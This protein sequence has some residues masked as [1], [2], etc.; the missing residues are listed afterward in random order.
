MIEAIDLRRLQVLRMVREHGTVTAAAAA[1]HLTPSAVSHQLRQLA[2]EVGVEL[3]ERDGRGVRLTAAGHRV[4]LHADRLHAAWEHVQADL[5]ALQDGRVGT[6]RLGAFASGVVQLLVPAAIELGRTLP[7]VE[8][9]LTE[10]SQ[11]ADGFARLLTEEIDVAL[12]SP[13]P[14]G[15]HLEDARF[16]QQRLVVEPMDLV[17]PGDHPLAG[18]ADATLAEVAHEPWILAGPEGWECHQIAASACAAAGFAPRVVHDAVAPMAVGALVAAHLGVALLPRLAPL[19]VG[20]GAVRVPLTGRST[21]TRTILAATRRGS[22]ARPEV[23]A[24]LAALRAVAA[25]T[26]VAEVV[27]D[28]AR[29]RAG[30]PVP[31]ASPS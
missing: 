28:A 22:S 2:R 12:V 3:L 10:L 18:R 15:P 13:L 19:P 7:G 9:R 23:A 26:G 5:A 11:S 20:V 29:D 31:A 24:G 21:P 25:S 16:E 4:V 14:D 27:A 6:L 1:L 17:V 30:A 8:P